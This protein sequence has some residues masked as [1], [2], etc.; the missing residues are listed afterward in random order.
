MTAAEQLADARHNLGL[1]L[2]DISS[3]TKISIERLSAIERVDPE[4]LPSLVY[5]KGF[6]RA[7]AAG[8]T[9]DPDAVSARYLSE[10]SRPSAPAAAET[11]P[12]AYIIP[13]A[14]DAF[15]AFESE[16]DRADEMR[17][18]SAAS[19]AFVPPLER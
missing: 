13:S 1:S 17:S 2:E 16:D 10:L 6:I 8:V 7:Y 12:G 15:G 5:L 19:A 14:K 9:L 11:S 4:G 18:P 3:R